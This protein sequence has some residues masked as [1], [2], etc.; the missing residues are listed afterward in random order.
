MTDEQFERLMY[1]LKVG[2]SLIW[3]VLLLIVVWLGLIA[4][5]VAG[6]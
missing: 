1:L 5:T 6:K 4:G 3:L 2:F